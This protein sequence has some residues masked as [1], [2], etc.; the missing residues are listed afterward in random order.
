MSLFVVSAL[1]LA[2]QES[3]DLEPTRTELK[4]EIER[5]MRLRHGGGF[6]IVSKLQPLEVVR[7]I[8][9][10]YL[11][12]G[13]EHPLPYTPPPKGTGFEWRYFYVSIYYVGL[14][15]EP[16]AL[17]M[18]EKIAVNEEFSET[19]RTYAVHSIGRIDPTASKSVLISLLYSTTRP[20]WGLRIAA[21]EALA[22]TSDREALS[23][24]E[25]WARGETRPFDKKKFEAASAKLR[26]KLR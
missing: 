15:H 14:F 23:E 21:A 7:E 17:P 4:A 8:V 12:S 13:Y 10:G 26:E 1:G 24:L 25:K 20:Q 19:V 2:L 22:E 9:L 5:A 16:R 6:D 3:V 11:A 18:L